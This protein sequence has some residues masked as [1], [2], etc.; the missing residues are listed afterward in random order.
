MDRFKRKVAERRESRN[1][2]RYE[3]LVLKPLYESISREFED[4]L[5]ENIYRIINEEI[6]NSLIN[7]QI[8]KS[9]EEFNTE[10]FL[11]FA[12]RELHYELDK[13]DDEIQSIEGE[14]EEIKEIHELLA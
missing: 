1:S 12:V 14:P 4:N 3:G 11:E 8:I 6:P 5:G 10:Q 7:S 2:E 13:F 9:K